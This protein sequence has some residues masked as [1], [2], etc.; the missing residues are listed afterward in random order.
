MSVPLLLKLP[1]ELLLKIIG[2][3]QDLEDLF[4][5]TL[6]CRRIFDIFQEAQRL[7]IE[8]TFAKYLRLN[9]DRELYRV[10]TQLSWIVR[11]DI[12]RRDVVCH[13]F[14]IGWEISKQ[15][16]QEELLIPLVEP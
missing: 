12:V 2:N 15:K 14:E 13:I 16:Y 4:S 3:L 7:L 10:L 5:A 1:P 8:S 11:R 9:T 6:V